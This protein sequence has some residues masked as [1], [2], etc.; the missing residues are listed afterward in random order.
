MCA[1]GGIRYPC[2]SVRTVSE[3]KH[4][5]LARKRWFKVQF[6]KHAIETVVCCVLLHLGCYRHLIL[7]P[8]S[9]KV[10]DL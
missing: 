9:E 8:G 2:S 5:N 10:A 4:I 1:K 6:L 3:N 7:A